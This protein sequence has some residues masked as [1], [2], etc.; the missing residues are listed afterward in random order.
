MKLFNI[1]SYFGA[2]FNIGDFFNQAQIASIGVLAEFEQCG[3]NEYLIQLDDVMS[4]IPEVSGTGA[5]IITQ[6]GAGYKNKDTSIYRSYY[7]IK[8]AFEESDWKGIGEAVQLT[9][10]SLTKFESADFSQNVITI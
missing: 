9:M 2:T 5:N 8:D 6:F 1:S 10:S 4:R 3:Y 7:I